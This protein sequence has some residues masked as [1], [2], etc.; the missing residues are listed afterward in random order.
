[1]K[2]LPVIRARLGD[3][4]SIEDRGELFDL[5]SDGSIMPTESGTP[6]GDE[7]VVEYMMRI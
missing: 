1:M 6:S 2:S 7:S 5:R 4:L 3:L